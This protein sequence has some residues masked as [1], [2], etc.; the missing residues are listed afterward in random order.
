MRKKVAR[1]YIKN[2]VQNVHEYENTPYPTEYGQF[3]LCATKISVAVLIRHVLFCA[4]S[5]VSE[6]FDF[7]IILK[8]IETD[9]EI[10]FPC[11]SRFLFRV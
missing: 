3:K 8:H 10:Q 9:R 1:I 11:S 4:G 6:R 2:R 5:F 7:L